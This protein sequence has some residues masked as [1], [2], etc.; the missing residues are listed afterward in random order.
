M[1]AQLSLLIAAQ[2]TIAGKALRPTD[3]LDGRAIAGGTGTPLVLLTLTPAATARVKRAGR[4]APIRL[5]GKPVVA[6]ILDA[7]I[8]LEGQ[9]NFD[10][11]VK[12]ARDISGKAP[13]PDSLD[14]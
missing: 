10:A 3:F 2:L 13:L 9:A 4:D 14:E 1:N 11:A 8:E 7:T 12:L 5:D 6:H